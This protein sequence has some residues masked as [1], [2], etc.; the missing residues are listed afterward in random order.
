MATFHPYLSEEGK[1][2]FADAVITKLVP[3]TYNRL[4][5][6][7]TGGV[8]ELNL[9]TGRLRNLLHTNENGEEIYCRDLLMVSDDKL[10]IGTESGIYIYN[11]RGNKYVHLHNVPNDPYS[12]S[13]NAKV[14]GAPKGFKIH[15]R[16][17][18]PKLGA[19][20]L[21]ALTGNILTMPGLPKHPAA[22]QIDVDEDGKI[23]GLF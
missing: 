2:E 16:E 23:S 7:S 15:V 10:W 1:E 9:T 12:L 3:G 13:D 22:E 4:Y 21:V 20:F 8:Q 5:I 19:Q 6:G 18:V 14:L 17:F 11:I